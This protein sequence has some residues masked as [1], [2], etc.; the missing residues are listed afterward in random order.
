MEVPDHVAHV[1]RNHHH[2]LLPASDVSKSFKVSWNDLEDKPF[3]EEVDEVSYV[4]S[5]FEELD[6]KKFGAEDYPYGTYLGRVEQIPNAVDVYFT[7]TDSTENVQIFNMGASIEGRFS[8]WGTRFSIY[9]CQSH[10]GDY[11]VHALSSSANAFGGELHF[12]NFAKI[13]HLPT[14]YINIDE[15]KSALGM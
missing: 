14:K 5:A 6:E 1:I 8:I 9:F 12:R 3:S 13:N 15:L 11:E 2:E 7:Y 4:V 10:L